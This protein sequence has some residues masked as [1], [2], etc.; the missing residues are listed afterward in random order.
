MV[1]L[2]ELFAHIDFLLDSIPRLTEEITAQL[3]ALLIPA[4]VFAVIFLII[5][6][7]SSVICTIFYVKS[8][9]AVSK[10]VREEG[11]RSIVNSI[12]CHQR[13]KVEHYAVEERKPIEGSSYV[14][15]PSIDDVPNSPHNLLHGISAPTPQDPYA[16]HITPI[17]VTYSNSVTA[18]AGMSREES[19]YS[20][21]E[22]RAASTPLAGTLTT[23]V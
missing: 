12:D 20:T 3:D 4:I 22:P 18:R 10:L 7:L 5:A 19:F 15:N 11:N 17:V 9:N 21:G 14:R 13:T 1:L 6:V 16:R 23:A 2:S 8:K